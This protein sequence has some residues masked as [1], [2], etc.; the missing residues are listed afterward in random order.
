MGN[1]Y[2]GETWRLEGPG[3]LTC[4]LGVGLTDDC[5]CF[6]GL[7]YIIHTDMWLFVFCRKDFL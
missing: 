3:T 2:H 7:V 5:F 6:V 4:H 1:K